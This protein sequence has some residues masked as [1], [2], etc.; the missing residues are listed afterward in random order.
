MARGE[1]KNDTDTGGSEVREGV[2]PG[3]FC[4][5]E[6]A[7]GYTSAGTLMKCSYKA[8]DSRARWRRA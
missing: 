7:R 5:P 1:R 8:G 2:H 4:S 6:G 3:A